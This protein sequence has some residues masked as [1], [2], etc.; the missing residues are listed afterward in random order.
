MGKPKQTISR[1]L[2]FILKWSGDHQSRPAVTNRLKQSTRKYRTSSPQTLS[3]LILLRI[4]FTKLPM[5]PT[6]L[7][8]SYLAFSPLPPT[9]KSRVGCVFSVA[10]SLRSPSLRVTEYPALWSPDFPLSW[11][12]GQNS[13]H[14]VYFGTVV[15]ETS[16]QNK[17]RI[18][19]PHWCIFSATF[20][21]MT[22]CGK[23]CWKHPWQTFSR[24]P[25]TALPSREVK[26][27]S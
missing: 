5:S 14:P 11:P 26:I 22:I 16:S 7:V 6:V 23:T 15:S 27:F 3:Y 8:S 18:Q 24:R 17:K 9:I 4:G 2:F 21:S 13:D 12:K 19:P 25:A 10:L 1:V 20:T